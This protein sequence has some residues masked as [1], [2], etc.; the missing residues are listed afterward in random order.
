MLIYNLIE[1]ANV[2][3]G[4]INYLKALLEEFDT[5]KGGFGIKFQ[6]FKYDEIACEDYIW[7]TDYLKL[8]IREKDW[9][10]IITIAGRSKHVWIDVFDSYSI[11]VLEQ[12][13]KSIHGLKLQASVLN[14]RTL[15]K[16]LS[17]LNLSSLEVILNISGYSLEQIRNLLNTIK[18]ILSPKEVILQVGFQDYPTKFQD[19]GLSKI[20][21]IKDA[22]SQRISF[23]DHSDAN[24]EEAIYLPGTAVALGATLIEKHV[25][26]SKLE[27]TYDFYSSITCNSYKR[28]LKVQK[29]FVEAMGEPFVNDRERFYLKKSLQTPII[30]N[31][32]RSGELISFDQ[33]LKYRRTRK[34]GLDLF[35]LAD[36]VKNFHIVAKD[37]EEG[38]ILRDEDLK[39]AVIAAVIACRLKSSR[40]PKKALLKIGD[41]SSIELCIKNTLRFTNVNHTVLATSTLE[42]D[43]LL[44]EYTYSDSVIF[45]LGDPDDVIQRYIDIAERLGIDVIVRITGDMPYISDKILQILLKSHFEK[46]ADY[47]TARKAAVGTNLEILNTAALKKI[48]S[49]F[50]KADYSE[51]MTFYFT[52]NSSYFKLNYVDLPDTLIR[53]YRLTLDYQEDLEMFNI[54]EEY[55]KEQ[56]IEYDIEILF[57]F[58]DNNPKVANMNIECSLTYKTDS[59]LIH[60]LNE[61]TKIKENCN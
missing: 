55:F 31:S 38:D 15:V 18:P 48:Q 17:D 11:N 9:N 12:N 20:S 59:A 28:Y 29:N 23:A 51:Y 41:L 45:H 60:L 6:V 27:T 61:K 44:K 3:G 10:E 5:F 8:F 54:I 53:D 42:E 21:I 35:R 14:N 36:L 39:K 50:H 4:S 7:Y 1:V 19:S 40:L 33:D 56:N 46:G 32:K 58:L 49:Y 24:S 25:K 34:N 16:Q 22:F 2:H 47:T 26:H 52:S 37:K 57:N 30:N 13:L 43:S